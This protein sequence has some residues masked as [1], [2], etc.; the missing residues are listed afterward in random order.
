MIPTA[1]ISPW[2]EI[3]ETAATSCPTKLSYLSVTH[4]SMKLKWNKPAVLV[5]EITS[6]VVYYQQND[7]LPD[8]DQLWQKETSKE[9]NRTLRG[10][11]PATAYTFKVQPQCKS[12]WLGT[13]SKCTS[14]ETKA[15]SPP[16]IPTLNTSIPITHDSIPLQWTKPE[17]GYEYINQY[18]V[19]YREQNERSKV[20]MK[21]TKSRETDMVVNEL[22][23]K[24]KYC[25]SVHCECVSGIGD[26]GKWSKPISTKASSPPGKPLIL[27]ERVTNKKVNKL[28][29]TQPKFGSKNVK[30]YTVLGRKS[31]TDHL[32][33]VAK[34]N[35]TE[36]ECIVE[37]LEIFTEYIFHIRPE[38]GKT[39]YGCPSEESDPVRT[40]PTS[41]PKS[42]QAKQ[43]YTTHNSIVLGWKPPDTCVQSIKYYTILYRKECEPSAGWNSNVHQTPN[44]P[45]QSE[46]TCTI[47]N[48]CANTSYMFKVRP[49]CDE[50]SGTESEVSSPE[51]T[52][53]V[54]QCGKPKRT[55]VTHDSIT[56]EWT[57][58]TY[59]CENVLYYMVWCK[60]NNHEVQPWIEKE[61][62]RFDCKIKMDRL[63]PNTTYILKVLPHMQSG[64]STGCEDIQSDPVTTKATSPPGKPEANAVTHDTIHLV[65]T[66]PKYGSDKRL[67]YCVEYWCTS[68]ESRDVIKSTTTEEHVL[69]KELIPGAKYVFCIKPESSIGEGANS[70]LSNPIQTKATSPPGKPVA[71]KVTHNSVHLEWTKPEV[72][73]FTSYS[74]IYEDLNSQVEINVTVPENSTVIDHLEPKTQYTFKIQPN[75]VGLGTESEPSDIIETN[76]VCKTGKPIPSVITH[77]SIQL[78]WDKPEFI[79]SGR[80]QYYSVSYWHTGGTK[81]DVTTNTALE[82][83]TLQGLSTNQTYHCEV[84]PKLQSDE[85]LACEASLSDPTKT[86]PTSEPGKPKAL[87]RTHD[88]IELQWTKPE[89]GSENIEYYVVSYRLTN[90]SEQELHRCPVPKL[91]TSES[92]KPVQ[93]FK[94]EALQPNSSYVF[95]VHPDCKRGSKGTDSCF[96]E[97]ILTTCTSVPGNLK[98]SAVTHDNIQLQWTKPEYGSDNI[99]H[100]VVSYCTANEYKETNPK[101]TNKNT[102]ADETQITLTGLNTLTKYFFKVHPECTNGDGAVYECNKPTETKATSSPGRPKCISVTHNSITIKWTIPEYGCENIENYIV[103]YFSQEQSDQ[104][105]KEQCATPNVKVCGLCSNTAYIFK[106]HPESAYGES[107]ESPVSEPIKTQPCCQPG[108]IV[109]KSVTH[110]SIQIEWAKP[111]FGSV[112]SYV[113]KCYQEK[114]R[115]NEI[116]QKTIVSCNDLCAEFKD[117]QPK[118]WYMF[119]VTAECSANLENI[120]IE[121][122]WSVPIETPN[123]PLAERM[124]SKSVCIDKGPPVIYKVP[125]QYV[126]EDPN[127]KIAKCYIGEPP[128]DDQVTEKVLMVVGATGAGKTTLINGITNYIFN[129]QW[130]DDFRFKLI[131]D[132]N[133]ERDQ[134]QS[135]TSW[136]T[137]YTFYPIEGSCI[138][139][140]LTIID[141]PGFG[142]CEGVERDKRITSQIQEF[143]FI[144]SP[145]DINEIHGI[146]FVTQSS[147][148]RLTPTQKYIFDSILAIF[149]RDIAENIFLMCTF[150]DGEL[151]PVLNAVKAANVPGGEKKHF[152]F[153]N[154]ALFA[155]VKTNELNFIQMFWKMGKQSFESFFK[156]FQAAPRQSLQMTKQVMIDRQH[157]EI[158]VERFHQQ[159]KMGLSKIDE[160]QQEE[161]VLKTHKRDIEANKNFTYE[162]TVT[163]YKAVNLDEGKYVTNCI[164]CKLTCHAD[165]TIDDDDEKYKCRAMG[166]LWQK[167]KDAHC[168][169]CP[170]KCHWK[171]HVN[172]DYYYVPE[173]V[174]EERTLEDLKAKYDQAV[175]G[176]TRAEQ[177]ISKNEQDLEDLRGA[178][179]ELVREMK[180]KQER[181]QEI[182]LKPNPLTE[183]SYIEILIQSETLEAERGFEKRIASLKM[184][185]DQVKLLSRATTV[186]SGEEMKDVR[187]KSWWQIWQK[188]F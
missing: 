128:T 15:T 95:Q 14:I 181:L 41:A 136:I 101:W 183:E 134:S 153:N 61:M 86:K 158:L 18:V 49:E 85:E 68:T 138:D 57:K 80:I 102:S 179:L 88:S 182:A 112:D 34:T 77:N 42:V 147:L 159:I 127:H 177:M 78:K 152:E 155:K 133:P 26:T 10:L 7:K 166:W 137:A 113:V 116:D 25:F 1:R 83:V 33:Q 110:S 161:Q 175:G 165:C 125:V 3:I 72:G 186:G 132:E 50:C 178:V 184:I 129:V 146:G 54:C 167:T 124:R 52:K 126:M 44:A 145:H 46:C 75:G 107:S 160:L 81:N 90:E 30:S 104:V 163:K 170:G 37:D 89:Y 28:Q 148:A 103:S 79:G 13:Q 9:T 39:V 105:Q 63:V 156:D 157:L 109:S 38:C 35:G 6:Y 119:E 20:I 59:D 66:K 118:S 29:W 154:S 58:P 172:K 64:N 121:S 162:V 131:T 73:T 143:L 27:N 135:Q 96:S 53:P 187:G 144:P 60:I 117:L 188:Y 98:S 149:G 99:K 19:K 32:R 123:R 174:P 24:V 12:G 71:T 87:R 97:P 74:V 36:T 21:F 168:K 2:S 173:E 17:H 55:S 150:A 40:K 16:G 120:G 139:Y 130:E 176:K 47:T 92:G 70:E 108:N 23:P 185:K 142:D 141:T 69:V 11:S 93:S 171:Q 51:K 31:S 45:Q 100:Y 82:K 56:W 48:L 8:S 84:T 164:Q 151:P 43:K 111:E 180:E 94:I 22:K 4:D 91:S 5:E 62:K 122:T 140:I 169:V 76:Q 65:W 115:R 106:V 67:Q 114:D